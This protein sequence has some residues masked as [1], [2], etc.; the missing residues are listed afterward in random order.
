MKVNKE[1]LEDMISFKTKI[2][3]GGHRIRRKATIEEGQLSLNSLKMNVY[4]CLFDYVV[5]KINSKLCQSNSTEFT[6][7][8]HLVDVGGFET[9][10]KN[11]L[12]QL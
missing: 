9:Q 8:L 6:T 7:P 3:P 12:Y 11:G 2:Y 4:S 10:D 5:D 1:E